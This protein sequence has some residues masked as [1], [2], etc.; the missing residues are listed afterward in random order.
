MTLLSKVWYDLWQDKSRTLQVVLVIA[1]GAIGIGLVVGGRNVI[2]NTVLTGW[3]AAEPP[4]I[5]VSVTPPMDDEQLQGLLRLEG[6]S[7]AEGLLSSGIEWRV[8]GDTE[9]TTGL[10]EGRDDYYAQ[11]MGLDGLLDGEFPTR[12][13]VAIGLNSIGPDPGVAIG[14]MLEIRFNDVVRVF[15]VV[16]LMDPIGPS[17]TF[18]INLR[19]LAERD[20]FARIT[21]RDTYNLI[22][23]RDAIWDP[24]AAERTDLLMQGYLEDN[25][26]DS[27]GVLFPFQDRISPPDVPPASTILN[28]IF[29]LLGLIGVIVVILGIF[30]VYNSISAI[31]MQQIGQ[32]GVLKAVGADSGQV[33]RTYLILVLSYGLL[34]AAI[35]IPGGAAAARGLQVFFATF[36]NMENA[37]PQ[38]DPTAVFI[39]VLICLIAPL[40]AALIPL[41]SGA[42]I[43][44]REA[45]STYGLTG[46]T[47]FVDRALA[48]VKV[49][50]YS[51]ILVIG[52]TFRNRRRAVVIMGSLI[53]AGTIFMAVLGLNDATDY[54]YG[55]KLRGIHKFDVTLSLND[56]TR[57]GLALDTA[58]V[59]PGVGA[60]EG[61][62]ISPAKVR[63]AEQ[64][65]ATVEDPRLTVF[66]LPAD[67][68][69]Y[70]PEMQTGRWL[71]AGDG[72]VAVMHQRLAREAGWSVGDEIAVT[73]ADGREV[74]LQIVGILNDPATNSAVYMPLATW[75]A[76]SGAFDRVN[77][78]WAQVGEDRGLSSA[79]VAD[80]LTQGL[81]G[82]GIGVR[83]TSTYGALTLDE[84]VTDLSGGFD[85][86]LQ[87]LAIMAVV[88]ALVGGVGLSG[89]LSLS[90]LERRR[91]IGVLR[92]IGA[93]SWQVIRLFVGE[94]LL[95]AIIGWLVAIPL[96][97]PVAYLLA[98][99]GLS[100][101]LDTQ[102]SYRFT[103][104]GLILWFVV[105]TTLAF[106]AAALPARGAAK[107]SVR[108]S[109]S[110]Q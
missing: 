55:D 108:E 38:V 14:D 51:I 80:L 95:L 85:L 70:V 11:Q 81:E 36:L 2:A 32:I 61:W 102:L 47:G 106:I 64:T 33:L 59:Q 72:R 48:S 67:T 107:I 17:P 34:A 26:L 73:A 31:V 20:T 65:Q 90:V 94:A 60:A 46:G 40:V 52:N 71:A 98:T 39:Q 56:E 75:Q 97:I 37:T 91:E 104:D 1:L 68:A 7:E 109:L 53:V 22:Q 27:V 96:S 23:T 101:A 4:N 43:T 92:S 16:G 77:T 54:T 63:S 89:V 25:N 84:I 79:V 30:L 82:R 42:R 66:G 74:N 45:I 87:L 57:S 49:V 13:T 19:V 105:I 3:Q 29:L 44:V 99:R 86:I 103:P 28:G 110:Y 62:L 12:N 88:I 15:P 78:V 100:F 76:E 41:R 6:V 93:S 83:A 18:G 58:L 8:Q 50:P 9:W 35:S 21:G 10:L 24:A 5:K 69:M